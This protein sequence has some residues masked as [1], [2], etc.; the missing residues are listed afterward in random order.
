MKKMISILALA[1][2]AMTVPAWAMP[3]DVAQGADMTRAEAQAK[4][5]AR[6]D[7]MDLNKDGKW[8]AA[9][10]AARQAARHE[11][12]FVALDA[13]KD[14]SVS[15]AEFDQARTQRE[16]QMTERRAAFAAQRAE[17]M[18]AAKAPVAGDAA[19]A[20][21]AEHRMGGRDGR[22]GRHHA[23]GGG[24]GGRG[25]YGMGPD[26]SISKADFVAKS[27]ARFDRMDANKDGKVT[28]VER[29]AAR[30]E[31]RSKHGNHGRTPAAPAVPSAK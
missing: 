30:A 31:M 1:A 22:G 28:A 17:R 19:K 16:A 23:M 15:K 3:A 27:L 13:N 14:G 24:R 18:A 25:G 29:Q 7:K 8:D 21:R 11:A 10:R 5:E 12:R 6:F 2:S 9:D 26:A 4:A 20:P